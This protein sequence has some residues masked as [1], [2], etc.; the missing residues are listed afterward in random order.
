MAVR[1]PRFRRVAVRAQGTAVHVGR[2]HAP[3]VVSAGQYMR[4]LQCML[5]HTAMSMMRHVYTTATVVRAVRHLHT[6]MA[7]TAGKQMCMF[8]L[9]R[10]HLPMAMANCVVIMRNMKL[11]MA[12]CVRVCSRCVM[13]SR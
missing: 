7:R 3:M 12:D 9:A 10:V 13:S 6:T 1:G 11:I 4:V 5:V 8:Y 2:P